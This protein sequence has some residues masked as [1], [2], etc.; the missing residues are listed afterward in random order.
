MGLQVKIGQTNDYVNKLYFDRF[1]K[2]MLHAISSHKDSL[3]DIEASLLK[4]DL[5]VA[6]GFDFLSGS[7]ISRNLRGIT[8]AILEDLLYFFV[9]F[10]NQGKMNAQLPKAFIV[11]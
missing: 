3:W 8:P 1:L 7:Q 6:L 4:P 5:Q 2:L 9:S 11:D 10:A